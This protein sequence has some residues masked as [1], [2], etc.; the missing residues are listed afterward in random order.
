LRAQKCKDK[1]K[2]LADKKEKL[3]REKST[4]IRELKR[5]Q[6]QLRSKYNHFPLLHQRYLLL[7]LLGKGGFSEVWSAF[8]LQ[9][10]RYASVSR[11]LLI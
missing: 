7:H 1:E 8:D 3:E 10:L 2:A 9:D 6:D 5:S 11:S 4:L